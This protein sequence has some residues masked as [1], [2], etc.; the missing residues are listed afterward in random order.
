LLNSEDDSISIEDAENAGREMVACAKEGV[1]WTRVDFNVVVGKKPV[2]F[3]KTIVL[4][5]VLENDTNE[6]KLL[7]DLYNLPEVEHYNTAGPNNQTY[8]VKNVGG[9][10]AKVNV[11]S[12]AIPKEVIPAVI[13]GVS[14]SPV[15][16]ENIQSQET[17]FEEKIV[18]Q[19]LEPK[20]T[21]AEQKKL[22][23]HDMEVQ[24]PG[25]EPKKPLLRAM[26]AAAPSFEQRQPLPHE[27][28]STATSTQQPKKLLP[29]E[30]STTDTTTLQTRKLLPHERA[31]AS[32]P[33]VPAQK[34]L[35]HE[36]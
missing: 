21:P 36:R 8:A 14:L 29:H 5:Q 11:L 1:Y 22:A 16:D 3:T 30:V 32:S 25:T 27:I 6:Q 28:T 7:D 31:V 20:A 23:P 26:N 15:A 24:T 33:A 13:D 34:L 19:D 18:A 2:Y 9:G 10:L 35:P 12:L 17:Y 4:P